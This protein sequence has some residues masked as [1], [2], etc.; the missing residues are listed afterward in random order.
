MSDP[1]FTGTLENGTG[2]AVSLSPNG[3][4]I[5]AIDPGAAKSPERD[6]VA[7]ADLQP[8]PVDDAIK[9]MNAEFKRIYEHFADASFNAALG[10]QFCEAQLR[11]LRSLGRI[12]SRPETDLP[13][14]GNFGVPR[15]AE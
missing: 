15:D 7:P 11:V 13:A 1:F 5:L 8:D 14:A 3:G 10:R 6:A 4:I 9:A 2:F 12:P